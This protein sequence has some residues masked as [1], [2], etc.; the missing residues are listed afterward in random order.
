MKAVMDIE[1]HKKQGEILTGL[2]YLGPTL[3]IFMK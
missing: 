2:L 1:N 3:V